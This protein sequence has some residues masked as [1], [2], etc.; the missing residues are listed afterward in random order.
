MSRTRVLPVCRSL[1]LAA[2]L[3]SLT[4]HTSHAQVCHDNL[5]PD[6]EF[7]GHDAYAVTGETEMNHDCMVDYLDYVLFPILGLFLVV[8]V[9]A[10]VTNRD[11]AA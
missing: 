8:I 7:C 9:V 4:T 5:W 2:F 11:N 3:L 10:L 6:G 1:L